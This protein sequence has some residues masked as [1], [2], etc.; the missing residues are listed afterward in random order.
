MPA[1]RF[2]DA[3]WLND[4]L[5]R[6]ETFLVGA[7][8]YPADAIFTYLGDGAD[9]LEHPPRE[10]F[11]TIGVQSLTSDQAVCDGGG[12]ELPQTNGLFTLTQYARLWSDRAR[13]GARLR[14]DKSKGLAVTLKALL[15]ALQLWDAKDSA[16]ASPLAEP[17][18]ITGPMVFN[19]RKTPFGWAS[20]QSTWE[21]KF[22]ADLS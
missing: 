3:I 17:A 18:R 15:K 19:G 20:V 9:L 6:L 7:R 22:K 11:L 5:D 10:S 1:T 4:L 14:K 2:E 13:F 12:R 8:V 16:N 21:I